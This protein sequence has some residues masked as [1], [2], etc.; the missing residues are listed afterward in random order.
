MDKLI[1]GYVFIIAAVISA[2]FVGLVVGANHFNVT[3]EVNN[4]N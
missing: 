3:T 2:F 4:E 1:R